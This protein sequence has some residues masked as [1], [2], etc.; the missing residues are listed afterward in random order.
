MPLHI[1]TRLSR[2]IR[3]S[4]IVTACVT[5]IACGGKSMEEHIAQAQ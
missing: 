2:I 5:L 4:L 1:G 3:A